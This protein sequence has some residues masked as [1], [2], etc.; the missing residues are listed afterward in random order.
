MSSKVDITSTPSGMSPLM[1]E[2]TRQAL[3]M[4]CAAAGFG[5]AW[6]RLRYCQPINPHGKKGPRPRR[7]GCS[8]RAQAVKWGMWWGGRTIKFRR[9]SPFQVRKEA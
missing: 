6:A 1:A 3:A 2:F 8:S 9:F 5:E 7:S 4:A